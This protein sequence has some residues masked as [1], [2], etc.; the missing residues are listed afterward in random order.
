[1]TTTPEAYVRLS[2]DKAILTFYYDTLRVER[3]GTTWGIGDTKKEE[4]EEY[5]AWTGTLYFPNR[6]IHTAVFD[7]SFCDFYPTSTNRWFYKLESLKSIEG[8]EHLNTS[9]VTDMRGMFLRCSSL[10]SLDLSSFDTSKVMDMSKMFLRCSSLTSLDLSS[11]DTS[12]VEN[13]SNMFSWCEHLTALDL[14]SFETSKVTDMGRMFYSCSSLTSLDLSRFDASKVTDMHSMFSGCQSL[15]TLDLSSFDTSKVTDMHSMFWGC[16]SLTS[17]DLS[18]FDTSKVTNMEDMFRD[19]SSLTT[20]D[21][22]S[23]ATSKVRC[24]RGMFDGCSSLTSLDLSSFDTSKVRGMSNMFYNCQSL[25]TIFCNT[26]WNCT[27]SDD[28]FSHCYSLKGAVPY[29]I[30]SMDGGLATPEM[31]YFKKKELTQEAEAYVI[32]SA[33]KKTLTFYY[34][35]ERNFYM[36]YWWG[37]EETTDEFS[38]EIPSWAGS[39]SPSN[40]EITKIVFDESFC[41]FL[42][43]TTA[44][45]FE[46]LTALEEICGLDNLNT[47]EVESMSR[48]FSGCSSLTALDLSRFDTSQVREMNELFSSCRQLKSIYLGKYLVSEDA[49]QKEVFSNCLSLT[50]ITCHPESNFNALKRMFE[51]CALFQDAVDYQQLNTLLLQS[52]SNNITVPFPTPLSPVLEAYVVQSADQTTLTFYY[53]KKCFSHSTPSWS[54]CKYNSNGPI[55]QHT[56][57]TTL[58]VIFSTSFQ[59]FHPTST[60]YWF[61]NFKSLKIIEGLE[62]LNIS[63]VTDMGSMFYSCSSLTSLNLSRFDTSKV[64]DMHEMFKDC[65]GLTSLDLSRFD[66]SKVTDMCSMFYSC[67]SLTSLDLSSFDTSEV[68]SMRI[69][70]GDCSSLTA[71]DLSSFDTSEVTSMGVMFRDCSSLTSLALS[72]FDTSK[73][74]NME[75]MFSDCSSLTSLDLSSF[76]TFQVTGM[77]RMFRDCSS[78]TSLDLSSFDTSQVTWMG[79]MFSGCKSLTTLDLSSFDTSKVTD[80]NQMFSGCSSLTSL[81][82]SRFDTSRVWDMRGMFEDCSSLTS[83]DLSSFDT[84]KVTYMSYMFSGCK[85]LITIYCNSSWN[86]DRSANMF[87]DCVSLSGAATYEKGRDDVNMANPQTGYFTKNVLTKENGA[88]VLLTADK[89]TLT[90][91]FDRKRNFH[92]GDCWLI[93]GTTGK[94]DNKIS[95]W[96]DC[97]KKTKEEITKVVIDESFRNFVP[98]TTAGW[99]EG[100]MALEEIRGLENLNTS[101]VTDMSRMFAGCGALRSLDV[102]RFDTLNVKQMQQMFMGCAALTELDLYFFDTAKVTDMHEMFKDCKGLTTLDLSNFQTSE[103]KDMR[104]MFS[105][106]SALTTIWSFAFRNCFASE[107]MFY[108]CISLQGATNF[109]E[110]YTDARMANPER[111]YFSRK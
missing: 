78:L 52:E 90:F 43:K 88:Y 57:A 56:R 72:S 54:V 89:K 97:A 55:W 49:E 27:E 73:V 111:G 95:L 79:G 93:E 22:S 104:E 84:F 31:G 40:K 47:S 60:A 42:P 41:N 4:S 2:A 34:D 50:Q 33:D 81:D 64:T 12:K 46:G 65:K 87:T 11:F 13:M 63:E 48:M 35:R 67:S 109:N 70:F 44:S 26:S 75:S 28:M 36:E 82:L 53:D 59:N 24:M 101:E 94:D 83:L 29:Q 15:T 51:N 91:Y 25:T 92:K 5:P 6:T 14:S 9:Q 69:M 23:F 61:Q 68:T 1:M 110:K 45:W 106:C 107:A 38:K 98:K 18:N 100:L 85:S 80:M 71:L 32:R 103:V 39:V 3:D 21:L 105:G 96:A 66:T 102:S 99:F 30:W 74:T 58:K 8:L 10:T 77:S 19:C 76:D 20:L 108:E 86:C 7:A 16:S 17:L 62:H 37:I